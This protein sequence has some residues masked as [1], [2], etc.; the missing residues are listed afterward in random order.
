MQ[1]SPHLS[2]ATGA[3]RD[4]TILF[5][6]HQLPSPRLRLVQLTPLPCPVGFYNEFIEELKSRQ[7]PLFQHLL[8][9]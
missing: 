8:G 2:R 5:K 1:Q 4:G 7:Q 3:C 6:A 9:S